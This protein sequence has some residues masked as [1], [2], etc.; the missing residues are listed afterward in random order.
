MAADP[1][2]TRYAQALFETAKAEGAIDET[3]QHLQQVGA[4]L[5]EHAPLR[6]LLWN[7]DVEAEEK[8]GVLDRALKGAW[9]ETARAFFRMVVSMGRAEHL[10]QIVEAFQEAVDE[11]QGRLR[12]TVRVAHPL[13][14]AVVKRLKTKLE[15]REHKSIDVRTE[16]SP[17]LLGGA[18]IQLDHRVIDGSVRRQLSELAQRLAGVRVH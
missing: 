3:L 1:I 16:L 14:E 6:E 18:Q 15:R 5:R 9:S 12:V 8:A 13:S 11:E 7:P 2:A 4:L 17:S 10:P